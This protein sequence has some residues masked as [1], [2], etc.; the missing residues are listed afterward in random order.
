MPWFLTKIREASGF[1]EPL[2]GLYTKRLSQSWGEPGE[3]GDV[4]EIA[5]VC[6]LIGRMAAEL[7]RWE[8]DVAFTR[9]PDEFEGLR[10]GLSGAA[11]RQLD[12]LMKVPDVIQFG[13]DQA[14]SA[15]EGEPTVVKH[16]IVFDLPEGWSDNLNREFEKLNSLIESGEIGID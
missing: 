5:H 12:E 6:S 3:A 16:T 1:L 10:R 13:I 8:E 9:L 11:G 4:E 14:T 7:V 15:P 2:Q